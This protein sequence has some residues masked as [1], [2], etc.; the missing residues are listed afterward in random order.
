[1]YPSTLAASSSL[2]WR[3]TRLK[4]RYTW[5]T[6]AHASAQPDC[7]LVV[8]RCT[9]THSQHPP[10][11]RHHLLLHGVLVVYQ[12]T[13]SHSPHPLPW[14]HTPFTAQLA[15]EPFCPSTTGIC[16][17][18][19]LKHAHVKLS[20]KEDAKSVYEYT[21]ALRSNSQGTS[22]QAR[23]EAASV[24]GCTGTLSSDSQVTCA[25]ICAA[26]LS[27][28]T[29]KEKRPEPRSEGGRAGQVQGGA[30][31]R[32]GHHGQL[33][34][35]QRRAP[36]LARSTSSYSYQLPFMIDLLYLSL[37]YGGTTSERLHNRI[38]SNACYLLLSCPY[39]TNTSTWFSLSVIPSLLPSHIWYVNPFPWCTG[40]RHRGQVPPYTRAS[41][42]RGVLTGNPEDVLPTVRVLRSADRGPVMHSFP[43]N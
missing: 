29:W 43:F 19:K 2:A 21:G 33:W 28:G 40:A 26:A 34:Q 9:R 38:A 4:G 14:P 11:W 16:P 27:L 42:S 5:P 25:V 7:L 10:P 37:R 8:H 36:S 39:I 31:Q 22:G 12:R 13:C 6:H 17:K 41:V 3:M 15:L 23:E 1:V 18:L 32:P 24:H 20:R 30:G 35:R